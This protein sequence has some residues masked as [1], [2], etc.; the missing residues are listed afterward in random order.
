MSSPEFDYRKYL[1]LVMKRRFLFTGIA[2]LVASLGIT[3]TYLK[4]EKYEAKSTVFIERSVLTDLFQGL[5]VTH[6]IE[7]RLRVL[8]YA[9]NT[10][11]LLARVVEELDPIYHGGD[12]AKRKQLITK[13]HANTEITIQ[14]QDLFTIVYQD[15]DPLLARDYV[16]TLIRTYIE[17]NLTSVRQGSFGANRFLVEQMEHF[18]RS[19]QEAEARL[20]EFR[21]KE[22]YLVSADDSVLLASIEAD[23]SALEELLIRKDELMARRQILNR[24]SIPGGTA[25]EYLAALQRRRDQLLLTYTEH[26]PE[27]KLVDA[28]IAQIREAMKSGKVEMTTEIEDGSLES[29]LVSVE[30]RAVAQ[31]EEQLRQA[32][33]EK[34]AIMSALPEKRQILTNL[35]RD[36]NTYFEAY[37]QLVARYGRSEVS[38]QIDIQDK[39]DTF[40]I[41]DAAMLPTA[42]VD[43]NR[44][45]LILL[46]L[47]AGLGVAYG[48]IFARDF[49]DNSLRGVDE[50]QTIGLPVL[51]IVPRFATEEE[52]IRERKRNVALATVA[53][54][55][56]LAVFGLAAFEF[57]GMPD[58]DA[59]A[60][61][62]LPFWMKERFVFSSRSRNSAKGVSS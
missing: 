38:K 48:I 20:A 3:L 18:R 19:L 24:G 55:Y 59:A 43:A 40:R 52:R 16:N 53:C 37:Q 1:A 17:E 6:S 7:E 34:Q 57:V 33:Q 31:R 60:A 12:E 36:R 8:S 14:G 58:P 23:R 10:R 13:F 62:L 21:Q 15:K 47:A 45:L 56:L 22:H 32:L 27:V 51:A 41:V 49:L 46:S 54:I 50:I 5:A 11:A 30:L 26:F 28:E 39:A 4:P 29:S 25:V 2:I 35:E 9:L 44:G 61:L 42:P